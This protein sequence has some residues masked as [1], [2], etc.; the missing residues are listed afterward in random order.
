M[1]EARY[2][3]DCEECAFLGTHGQYDLYF[4]DTTPTV[5]ARYGIDGDYLSGLTQAPHEPVLARAI[6]KAISLGLLTEE[7]V[8]A[9][10]SL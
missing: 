6:T 7:R 8:K 1:G 2:P 9:L 4:C 5:I 10:T 3:H